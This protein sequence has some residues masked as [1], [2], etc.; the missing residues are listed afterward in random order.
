MCYT[1]KCRFEVGGTGYTQ[2]AC[3][4]FKPVRDYMIRMY[5]FSPQCP[6]TNLVGFKKTVYEVLQNR[7]EKINDEYATA[8]GGKVNSSW[9]KNV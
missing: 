6:Q 3:G 7:L 4:V 2:G 9:N 8:K 1:G 5:G